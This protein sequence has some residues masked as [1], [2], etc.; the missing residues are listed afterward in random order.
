[1]DKN[2]NS[3]FTRGWEHGLFKLHLTAK[4]KRA[5]DKDFVFSACERVF[6][7]AGYVYGN[8]WLSSSIPVIEV[9]ISEDGEN[10]ISATM[11]AFNVPRAFLS[12][13]YKY[14]LIWFT[15]SFFHSY[16]TQI[17]TGKG[18]SWFKK[19][20][21]ISHPAFRPVSEAIADI[22]SIIDILNSN[23]II[24]LL[25]L[26]IQVAVSI[27]KRF[28]RQKKLKE[29]LTR[30]ISLVEELPKINECEV[31]YEAYRDIMVGHLPQ[32]EVGRL[33]FSHIAKTGK[34]LDPKVNPNAIHELT[35]AVK[36]V[37]KRKGEIVPVGYF[38]RREHSKSYTHV[39]F[40]PRSEGTEIEFHCNLSMART[41]FSML[42]VIT[43][44]IVTV[45]LFSPLITSN[46]TPRGVGSYS[47]S[48]P[49][50]LMN[51][52]LFPQWSLAL[53]ISPF[54]GLLIAY[55]ISRR[56]HGKARKK[57]QLLVEVLESMK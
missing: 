30:L 6:D 12:A 37:F 49:G 7:R 48:L 26:I 10:E 41:I 19:V 22:W 42:T 5:I 28:M 44:C 25:P 4:L 39:N 51:V 45:F 53:L 56:L 14:L 40:S 21:D 32:R 38:I 43:L 54:I 9:D 8:G 34:Q 15:V 33:A 11:Q 29:S 50:H 46:F 57:A 23:F 18:L 47:I 1:M 27:A 24:Y 20:V 31:G 35:S 36:R 3:N 55:I 13:I 17:S 2:G 16:A 52:T